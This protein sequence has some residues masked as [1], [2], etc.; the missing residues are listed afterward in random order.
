MSSPSSSKVTSQAAS[1]TGPIIRIVQSDT[2]DAAE[3]IIR[4]LSGQELQTARIAVLN[5]AS[6]LKPGGGVMNGAIAQEESLCHR[7]TLYPALDTRFYRIKRGTGLY[8]KDVLVRF[9]RLDLL[10]FPSFR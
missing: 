3:D 5:M 2:F 7:S 6:F 8:T 9:S 10:I 4:S 1:P